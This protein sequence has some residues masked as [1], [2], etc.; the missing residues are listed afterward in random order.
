[1]PSYFRFI[2]TWIEELY[3]VATIK[4]V[5]VESVMNREIHA[6]ENSSTISSPIE[7]WR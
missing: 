5:V 6:K 4:K 2:Q 1:V 3:K 7:D